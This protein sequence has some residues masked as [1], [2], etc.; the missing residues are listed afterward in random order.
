MESVGGVKTK[1]CAFHDH[2]AK[3]HLRML[4]KVAVQC[5]AI[6]ILVKMHPI[7]QVSN[8]VVTLLQNQELVLIISAVI[9]LKITTRHVAHDH[10]KMVIRQFGVLKA[11]YCNVGF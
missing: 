11:L 1:A 3:H 9:N 7:G 10:I 5:N 4:R 6:L 8:H 2:I